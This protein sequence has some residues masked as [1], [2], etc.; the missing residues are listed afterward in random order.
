MK[1]FYLLIIFVFINQIFSQSY[2]LKNGDKQS[3]NLIVNST[4][5][6]YIPMNQFQA[7][8]I[9]MEFKN[10]DPDSFFP[11]SNVEIYEYLNREGEFAKISTT[12][13][14]KSDNQKILALES[15]YFFDETPR[16]YIALSI[17]TNTSIGESEILIDIFGGYYEIIEN[18]YL[19]FNKFY[20]GCPYYL[21]FKAKSGNKLNIYLS[22][23]KIEE[24]DIDN[25]TLIEYKDINHT[26]MLSSIDYAIENKSSENPKNI[27][28]TYIIKNIDTNLFIIKLYPRNYTTSNFHASITVDKFYFYLNLNQIINIEKL[29]QDA[30]YF[31][32]EANKSLLT[33]ISLYMNYK[34]DILPF[35]IL[36]IYETE[37][38]FNTT[39]LEYSFVT[40]NSPSQSF[41]YN[42]INNFTK[43]LLIIFKPQL[44]FEQIKI[45][46]T[47]TKELITTY[48]MINGNAKDIRDMQ[49][50]IPYYF[51][52]DAS[53]L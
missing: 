41:I 3:F 10:I 6:F 44:E 25:L 46:Y 47:F 43:F 1:A 20:S 30:Y 36:V 33:N 40:I 13:F 17:T 37:K 42:I 26:I 16:N 27:D 12:N 5:F 48:N 32:L 28:F 51:D 14:T 22:F 8:K 35:T 34:N 31:S 23:L 7:A 45:T 21:T 19:E 9:Y 50:K 53:Y 29:I 38:A 2:D 18:N 11:F 52:I 24:L 39:H 15:D 4:Y 49:P